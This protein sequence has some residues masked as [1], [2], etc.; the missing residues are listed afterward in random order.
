MLQTL[1]KKQEYTADKSSGWVRITKNNIQKG[2]FSIQLG[3]TG[4]TGT[5]D[6]TLT[7][8]ISNDP[9]A[10]SKVAETAKTL[11][12]DSA[13]IETADDSFITFNVSASYVKVDFTKNNLTSATV[14][15]YMN[16]EE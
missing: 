8:Y 11:T 4:A 5:L 16:V 6:G 13:A 2:R 14:Y 1:I 3:W 7:V 9:S 12:I 15:A 10:S